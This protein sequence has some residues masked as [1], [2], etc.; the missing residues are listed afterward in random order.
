MDAALFYRSPMT[1][2]Q[3]SQ[4]LRYMEHLRME[5]YEA[6]TKAQERRLVSEYGLL[7]KSIEPYVTGKEPYSES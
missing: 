3:I 6:E 1:R 7:W 2:E 5:S 4:T